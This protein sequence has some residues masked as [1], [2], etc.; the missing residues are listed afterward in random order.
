MLPSA[1]L[2]PIVAVPHP[3]TTSPCVHT[4]RFDLFSNEF[5]GY[6]KIVER[7]GLAYMATVR[8]AAPSAPTPKTCCSPT[9]SVYGSSQ[10][11]DPPTGD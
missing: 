6:W 11:Y 5:A 7:A 4:R 3:A 1:Y 10:L 2:P 9:T 8:Q